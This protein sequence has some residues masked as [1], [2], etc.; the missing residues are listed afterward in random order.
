MRRKLYDYLKKWKQEEKGRIALMI[1]GARRIGK[2]WLVE[3]FAK[4]E[5]RSYILVDF[6]RISPELKSVFD[7]YL[8]DTDLFFMY[9]QTITGI[10][11]FKRESV[12]IFDEVQFY[13]K[14]REAV[15][16]LVAD[17]KYD[18]IETGSLVSIKRN[19]KG[20]LIPSEERQVKMFPMDFEEFL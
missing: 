3:E 12:I 17:G 10:K 18:Y 8:Y 5:Y 2:S 4:R 19:T 13:P 16:H 6:T 11:L 9:L 7:N 14:A 20:I 15:K 1:E